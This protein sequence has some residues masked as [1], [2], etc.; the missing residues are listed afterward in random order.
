MGNYKVD[1]KISM[2]GSFERLEDSVMFEPDMNNPAST[3]IVNS[4][5]SLIN[6]DTYRKIEGGEAFSGTCTRFTCD[7]FHSANIPF[8]ETESAALLYDYFMGRK[9]DVRTGKNWRRDYTPIFD[10]KDLKKGDI[11]FFHGEGVSELHTGVATSDWYVPNVLESFLYDSGVQI[12]H[13]KGEHTPVSNEFKNESFM[14]RTET[15][16]DGTKES[17]F[18]VAFRYRGD[19]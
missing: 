19:D 5:N 18:R 15:K 17:M 7:V 10:Y 16:D 12:V 14:N 6:T 8:P 2:S 13:D 9:K 11:V 4:A 1:R 3:R